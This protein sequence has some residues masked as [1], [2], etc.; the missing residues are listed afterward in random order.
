MKVNYYAG[1]GLN[2]PLRSWQY[3]RQKEQTKVAPLIRLSTKLSLVFDHVISM[4]AVVLFNL[5]E[6]AKTIRLLLTEHFKLYNP[7]RMSFAHRDILT[8][9]RQ[10]CTL[11][12]KKRKKKKQKFVRLLRLKKSNVYN[13]CLRTF[14]H[15]CI[16]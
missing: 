9:Q 4:R 12:R 8:R 6:S 7:T 14:V 2:Q 11:F 13:I 3:S 10:T 16:S 15:D 5:Y 1:C